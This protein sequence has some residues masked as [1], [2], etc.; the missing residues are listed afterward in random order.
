MS[1]D[2]LLP[3]QFNSAAMSED[4]LP[5]GEFKS[6]AWK[7]AYR[8]AGLILAVI[9]A[10]VG[11]LF[12]FRAGSVVSFFNGFARRWGLGETPPEGASLFLALAAAY[13]CVVT[14]LALAMYVRPERRQSARL[15]IQAKAAS[16]VI[17]LILCLTGGVQLILLANAV[18]DGGIALAVAHMEYRGRVRTP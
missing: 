16:A 2:A 3:G 7:N 5:P 1:G 9:F 10:A 17:S 14:I 15:L 13:M 18:V 12:L 8:L 6:T 11:V 4:T